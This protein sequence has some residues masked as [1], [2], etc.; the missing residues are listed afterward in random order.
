M[1]DVGP[2][3][4]QMHLASVFSLKFWLDGSALKDRMI[5]AGPI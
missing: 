1:D 2:F 4:Q 5:E 3:G